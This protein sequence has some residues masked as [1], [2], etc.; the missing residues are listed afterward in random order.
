[1]ATALAVGRPGAPQVQQP[2]SPG[3]ALNWL[4][5]NGD[6]LVVG[7][8]F[9][10]TALGLYSR[11]YS[12]IRTPADA[13]LTSLQAVSFAGHARVKDPAAARS[14]YVATLNAISLVA[15]PMFIATGVLG[16]TLIAGLY[17]PAW[18]R[19]GNLVRP[20]SVAMACH[21]LVALSGPVLWARD[22]VRLE[23]IAQIASLAVLAVALA[24]F[25]GSTAQIARW[26]SLSPTQ[27]VAP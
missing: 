13:L 4:I 8:L 1:M 27:F 26:P 2:G 14:V 3:N 11:S 24:A 25:S 15:L 12:T 22:Q 6:N 21:C 5:E 7:R 19:A 10:T 23:Y 9:G 20:L 18:A 17:G 16:P